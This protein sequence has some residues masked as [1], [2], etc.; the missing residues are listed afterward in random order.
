MQRPA[1]KLKNLQAK[2]ERKVARSRR[3]GA[4]SKRWKAAIGQYQPIVDGTGDGRPVARK[5]AAA[6]EPEAES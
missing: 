4:K 6:D 3:P 5:K 1:R 2:N